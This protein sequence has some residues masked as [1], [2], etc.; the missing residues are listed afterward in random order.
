MSNLAYKLYRYC[1]RVFRIGQGFKQVRDGRDK[2]EHPLHGLL[3]KM[4]AGMVTGVPSFNQLAEMIRHGDFDYIGG[5]TRPGADTF[6]RAFA[7]L[8]LQHLET[9]L[10]GIIEKARYNKALDNTRV[11]GFRVVAIDGTGLFSTVCPE[12][13]KHLHRHERKDD[14]HDPG[15]SCEEVDPSQVY[16]LEKA[17]AVSYVGGCGPTPLLSLARIPK[18]KGESTVGVEVLKKLY[19]THWRYCDFVTLDAGFA[20]AP[21]LNEV[22]RQ[23][24]E[25]VVRVKQRNYDIIKDATALFEGLPPSQTHENVSLRQERIRFDLEIWDDENFTS[26][27]QVDKPLRCIKIRE[28]RKE[29]NATGEIIKT[30]TITTHLVTSASRE[31]V[32]AL[33]IWEMAH[34]RWDIENTGIHFLKHHFKIEHAYS[35]D[36]KVIPVMLTLFAIAYN[37]FMLFVHRNLRSFDRR[38]DTLLGVMRRIYTG[39]IRLE[40]PLEWM[41]PAM[42]VT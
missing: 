42:G 20:G 14:P 16:Y 38:R 7:R 11:A 10:D 6:P 28:T 29:L 24:K 40:K 41:S 25:F 15:T 17:L 35:Y 12:L 30:Q 4:I 2:P 33:S 5:R 26:W 19:A 37:L 27:E 32:P 9:V 8:E 22:I 31:V 3:W 21:I 39:L 36:P 18:G 1:N 13:G 23:N 34:L